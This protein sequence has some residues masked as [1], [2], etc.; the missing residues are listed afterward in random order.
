MKIKLKNKIGQF[1]GLEEGDLIKIRHLLSFRQEGVEYTKAFKAGHWDGTTYLINSKQEFPIGLLSK[2]E[3]YLKDKCIDYTIEDNRKAIVPAIPLDISKPLLNIGIVPRDYQERVVNLIDFSKQDCGIIRSC[4]GSGKSLMAALMTAKI[5]KPTI[6]YVIGLDLLSQ[7]HSAF[8][9]IFDEEIGYIGNGVCNI[10]RINIASIWT[11]GKALD[12]SIEDLLNDDDEL[13]EE[14]FNEL[15]KAKIIQCLKDTKLHILDECHVAGT[16]TLRSIHK[17]IEPEYL[18]GLSGTPFRQDNS[19]LLIEGLLG[20]IKIDISASELIEKN[21][22]AQPYIKFIKVPSIKTKGTY[23]SIYKEFVVENDVRNNIIR[24]EVL[25]L[26]GKGYKPLVLFKQ[27]KHGN[28][29]A[30]LFRDSNIKFDILSGKD[31]LEKRNIIKE[32]YNNNEIDVIL[33]STIFDIGVDIPKL[34]SLVLAGAG[35]SYVRALQRIGRVIRP[36]PGKK[37][38]AIVD[39]YDDVKYLK[40]HSETRYAI[41]N[42]EKGFKVYR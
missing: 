3:K 4:T 13:D 14:S 1:E 12:I 16:S 10:K 20:P 29:L 2:V 27:I 24:K 28:I 26:I 25:S 33:A 18:Y 9:N 38:A 42:S 11:L 37:S 5:N 41:Y 22:L 23:Q 15:D 34:N 39:F 19:D 17:V 35:K 7:F 32:K 31:S 6:I 8:S 30:E 36:Y 21:V 40:T